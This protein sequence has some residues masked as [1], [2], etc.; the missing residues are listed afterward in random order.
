M[1]YRDLKP[2]NVMLDAE[3][4]IRLIDFGLAKWDVSMA[5]RSTA[6]GTPLYMTP[7]GV[8]NFKSLHNAQGGVKVGKEADWYALGTLLYELTIGEAPFQADEQHVLLN[9]IMSEPLK[10]SSSVRIQPTTGCLCVSALVAHRILTT[11]VFGQVRLTPE[12]RDAMVRLMDKDPSDRLGS[13][14]VRA[15]A[16]QAFALA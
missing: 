4:H 14:T 3:G 13:Y 15:A 8:K 11:R 16:H 5:Q 1:A 6:C 9:K 10:I 7:E 12:A 2:E